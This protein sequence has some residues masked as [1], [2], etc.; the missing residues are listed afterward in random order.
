MICI[1]TNY[2][3]SVT[4]C[5]AAFSLILGVLKKNV[6]SLITECKALFVN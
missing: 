4:I 3:E 5:F 1:Y 6:Y 2:L